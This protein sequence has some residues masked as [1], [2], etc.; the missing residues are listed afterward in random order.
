M[1]AEYK[2][3]TRRARSAHPS[4]RDAID[5]DAGPPHEWPVAAQSNSEAPDIPKL[6]RR[7]GGEGG[8][9]A[10]ANL[11]NSETAPAQ[12]ARD[13][14][15]I[16][17]RALALSARTLYLDSGF[18]RLN[19]FG[20]S[21]R[22]VF[23]GRLL[24]RNTVIVVDLAAVVVGVL[25]RAAVR[26]ARSLFDL[27]LLERYDIAFETCRTS[28]CSTGPGSDPCPSRESHRTRAPHSAGRLSADHGSGFA[29]LRRR[30]SHFMIR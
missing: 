26:I 12:P 15:S 3:V 21:S 17:E 7:K 19:T 24:P 23:L 16:T 11:S 5:L 25:G 27:R 10:R 18:I 22:S 1:R 8:K 29:V 2:L 6:I 20:R 28:A 4:S 30:R 9:A 14:V 13:D